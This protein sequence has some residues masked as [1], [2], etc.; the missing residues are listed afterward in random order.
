MS[1]TDKSVFDLTPNGAAALSYVLGFFTG[2][3]V[4]VL[5]RNNRYVRFHAMQST[6]WF[7]MLTVVWWVVS[8]LTNIPI[9]GLLFGLVFWPVTFFGMAFYIGS[10]IFL[11]WKAYNGATFKIPVIGAVA[12]D[13]VNK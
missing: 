13:Q 10:K 12:W 7:L 9:L 3:M 4:L 1:D 11:I 5:E 6:L 2:I 8:I